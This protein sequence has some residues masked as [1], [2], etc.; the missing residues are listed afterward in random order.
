MGA[1]VHRMLDILASDG[2]GVINGDVVIM[3]MKKDEIGLVQHD[4]DAG[5]E[6]DFVIYGR[7]SSELGWVQVG[8]T[9][10]GA[11]QDDPK[12]QEQI[13]IFPEMYISINVGVARDLKIFL[14]E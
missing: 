3:G 11:D 7:V 6:F 12:F 10:T 1:K 2:T 9:G 5:A 14:L 4:F 13:P 8:L